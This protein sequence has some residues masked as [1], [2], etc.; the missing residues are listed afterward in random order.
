MKLLHTEIDVVPGRK[1]QKQP[2]P[3]GYVGAGTAVLRITN[4]TSRQNAYTVRLQCQEPYWQDAWYQLAALP[5]TGGAENQPPPGKPDQL[6]PRN[7]TL[8]IYVKDGG[9]RDIFISYFVPEK[10]ECR[11]GAYPVKIIVETRILS[12]DPQIARQERIT[13]CRAQLSSGPS[14]S[15]RSHIHPKRERLA[16]SS[17]ARNLSL[18]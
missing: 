9:T 1:P 15:G 5:P 18:P 13:D 4:T 3:E 11:A 2:L 6:G 7:Q 10:S 17:A 14:T 16:S 8:T 12:D